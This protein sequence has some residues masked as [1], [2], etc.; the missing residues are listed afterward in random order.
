MQFKWNDIDF[1]SGTVPFYEAF[2]LLFIS[3]KSTETNAV[4]RRTLQFTWLISDYFLKKFGL[5]MM[6]D[7]SKET[8]DSWLIPSLDVNSIL[9]HLNAKFKSWYQ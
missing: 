3:K 1:V 4:S 6:L 7:N 2:R 9:K 8:I 5:K